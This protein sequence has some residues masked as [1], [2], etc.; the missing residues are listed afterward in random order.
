LK[1]SGEA[2]ARNALPPEAGADASTLRQAMKF[3]A[4]ASSS[5]HPFSIGTLLP[6]SSSQ[7]PAVGRASHSP[8]NHDSI[9]AP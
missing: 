1:D 5:A 6:W 3:H 4:G 9:M 7:E 8:K 2:R